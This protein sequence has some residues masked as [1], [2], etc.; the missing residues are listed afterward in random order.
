MLHTAVLDHSEDERW[1]TWLQLSISELLRLCLEER[2]PEAPPP[3]APVPAWL[4]RGRRPIQALFLPGILAC[5]HSNSGLQLGPPPLSFPL[6]LKIWCFQ[7]EPGRV[8]RESRQW[9]YPLWVWAMEDPPPPHSAAVSQP[10]CTNEAACLPC[11]AAILPPASQQ[12]VAPAILE[13]VGWDAA[14][15]NRKLNTKRKPR[16]L[17]SPPLLHCVGTSSPPSQ[18][19]TRA[20]SP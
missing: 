20:H 14:R 9:G 4:H 8:G 19:T 5:C 10:L 7:E 16:P 12:P 13:A 1:L 11:M 18:A 17:A 2:T 15:K 6:L 3:W